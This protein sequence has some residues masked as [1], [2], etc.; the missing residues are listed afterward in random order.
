M[1]IRVAW[2]NNA[3]YGK[4]ALMKYLLFLVGAF[5][6]VT[7]HAEASLDVIAV[8]EKLLGDGGKTAFGET[9][10]TGL[11]AVAIGHSGHGENAEEEAKA[12]AVLDAQRALAS[13]LNAQIA[14]AAEHTMVEDDTGA[15][16][17]FVQWTRIDVDQ[18][19]AGVRLERLMKHEGEWVAFVVMT[20]KTVDATHRLKR[21]IAKERPGTVE[22][23]GMGPTQE[24][25]L[26][27]ACRSAL[28][29]VCGTNVVGSSATVDGNI[30][31]RAYSDVQGMVSAYRIVATSREGDDY[32]VTILAEV[33][34]D[35]LQESYGAQMKSMGDPLFWIASDNKDVATDV[36]DFLMA[37]GLKTTFHKG[38]SDYKVDLSAE[39]ND[40]THPLDRRKGVQ[41]QLTARCY[42]KTG[43]L[44]F[45]LAGDP[46]KATVF[47]G[48]PT[49]QKQLAATKAVKQLSGELHKRLHCAIADRVNNGRTVRMVFRNVMSAEQCQWIEGITEAINDM[50]GA[51]SATYSRNDEVKVS[52]IRFTLKGNPQDF[53]GLLR[54]RVRDLPDAHSISPNKIIF[55][56]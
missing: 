42:D 19:L 51:S 1:P 31:A 41:L 34:K 13:F 48:N 35:E 46:R 36:A 49:R 9:D 53:V 20:E 22:A 12:L 6:C 14:S 26:Q 39:F 15:S 2:T 43:V 18:A 29:Q 27:A 23:T 47:I 7:L 25:A 4:V 17:A 3:V 50:P 24:I 37:K 28:E 44:M 54:E 33:D 38:T 45:S 40:V 8:G 30:R 21:V 32:R 11:W 55:E 16:A 56:L 10:R 5:F 52:T